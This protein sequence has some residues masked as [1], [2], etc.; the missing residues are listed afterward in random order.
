MR[1][2]QWGKIAIVKKCMTFFLNGN[3]CH[4]NSYS[5]VKI[6]QKKNFC[7]PFL[8]AETKGQTYLH[9]LLF[10]HMNNN[11]ISL[12]NSHLD[13]LYNII[14]YDVADLS[15]SMGRLFSTVCFQMSPQIACLRRGIVTLVA[16]V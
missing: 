5:R 15:L 10:R 12:L 4:I 16:F 11:F 13:I 8:F 9:Y 14:Y 3:I 2:I 1:K 6:K 7:L